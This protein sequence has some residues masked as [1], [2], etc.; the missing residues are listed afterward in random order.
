LYRGRE[1][2]ALEEAMAEL[3]LN[4]AVLVT[5]FDD[6]RVANQENFYQEI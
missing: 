1:V 5:M 2:R 4:E 6:E 3:G